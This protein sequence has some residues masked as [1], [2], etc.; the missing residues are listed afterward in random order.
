MLFSNLLLATIAVAGIVHVPLKAR[1][2]SDSPD[3]AAHLAAR[4]VD[5]DTQKM[6]SIFY[7]AEIEIGTP[8]QKVTVCFDTGSPLLWVPGANSTQCEQPN[9]C[10]SSFDNRKSSTWKYN[11]ETHNWGGIGNFGVDTVTYAGQ[12]LKDFQVWVS[13]DKMANSMGIFGQSGSDDPTNSFVQGLAHSGKISRAVYSLN[14]EKPILWRNKATQGV[15]NNVYYGGFDRAKYEGPLTTIKVDH[16]GGYAMPLGGLSIK[17]EKVKTARDHQIVLDT[18]GIALTLPNNTLKLISQKNGGNGVWESG[19]YKVE[20]GSKPE[21][22]YEFGYTKIDVD[23]SSY[24]LPSPHGGCR[25]EGVNPAEDNKQ[26]LLNG[27]PLISKALLIYDNT[28]DTITVGKAKYTD[29]SDVVEITGDIPGAVKYEDWLAG[30]P[31]PEVSST[32][33]SSKTSTIPA[34]SSV[35]PPKSSSAAPKPFSAAPTTS[36]VAPQSSTLA[37]KTTSTQPKPQ[38]SSTQAQPSPSMRQWCSWFGTFCI[39]VGSY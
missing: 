11:R 17:G 39:S 8:P 7:E 32:P 10:K 6:G 21:I 9:G 34:S 15:V 27:P 38:P 13:K 19:Y 20:C 3:V 16:H 5:H 1:D 24:V 36:K 18:G 31:L 14:A 2:I 35:T 29:E 4:G 28:R 30:K 23:L 22:T 12:T 26:I 33:T 37:I 25:L